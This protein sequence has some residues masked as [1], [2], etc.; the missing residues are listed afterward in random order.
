MNITDELIEKIIR[1]NIES[2]LA[3]FDYSV[4]ISDFV[5][6]I[7]RD[8]IESI[9]NIKINEIIDNEIKNVL[10]G[11]I[12][13]DNGWG[14][15]KHY[16]SFEDLFKLTFNEKLNSTWEIKR[17]I[18]KTIQDNVDKLIKNKAKEL[19]TKIQDLVLVELGN[20]K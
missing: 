12:D 7:A 16:N 10:A 20:D 17:V 4:V 9:V 8:K 19:T 3:D 5:R 18:E 13:T 15:R 1:E 2:R 14:D 6:K 11:E